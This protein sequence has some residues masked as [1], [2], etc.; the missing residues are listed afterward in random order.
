MTTSGMV[1][2]GA[3]EAGGCAAVAM[4]EA[5]W[6]GPITI[7]GD[8]RHPPYERPPLSKAAI[9]AETM[10]DTRLSAE[11]GRFEDLE[12]DHVADTRVARIDRSSKRIHIRDGGTIGYERLLLATGAQA[13]PLSVEGGEYALT[14]RSQEDVWALRR[15]FGPGRHVLI[16]GGGLIGLELAASANGLGATAT[17]IESQDRLLARSVR[18]D[19]ARRIERTHLEHGNRFRFNAGVELVERTRVILN[20]GERI[21][22]DIVVA[23]IGAKPDV[24]L[25]GAAG[26]TVTDG[27]LTDECLRTSDPD[28]FACGDCAATVHRLF[29]GTPQRMES[30]QVARDQG[31]LA[32]RNMVLPPEPQSAVPWFWSDQY[33]RQLQVAGLPFLGE[34]VVERS[35]G[36]DTS[37]YFYL[38]GDGTLVGAAAFGRM[39]L[40]AKDM[41]ISQRLIAGAIR[42]DVALLAA[43][44]RRLKTLLAA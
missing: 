9:T 5:G 3:G 44:D 33:D 29:S 28:I 34:T 26:L 38:S 21:D 22:G 11:A 32:G 42:P 2:I 19:I 30:W 41:L 16:V 4:R 35:L 37:L 20:T 15:F 40:L 24:A 31:A 10:P 13:R 8:E 7:L 14:L 36:A 17:I 27:V 12:I 6:D 23:A 1:I 18:P 39:R 25:A 43:P